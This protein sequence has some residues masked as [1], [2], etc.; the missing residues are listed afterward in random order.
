L[1]EEAFLLRNKEL[2]SL[3]IFGWGPAGE[4]K[5]RPLR[6]ET[7][8]RKSEAF[9]MADPKANP[10]YFSRYG[11]N[12]YEAAVNAI[13][14]NVVLALRSKRLPGLET[15]L[16]F[17]LEKALINIGGSFLSAY[18]TPMI[19]GVNELDIEY[20]SQ[21]IAAAISSYWKPRESA[22]YLAME[23][24]AISLTSHLITTKSANYAIPYINQNIGNTGVD[25][26]NPNSGLYQ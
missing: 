11:L 5:P 24:L 3:K 7:K 26:V 6:K 17:G 8:K 25:S 16:R 15:M 22:S 10:M 14:A 23:Q 20:L 18:L 19:S 13:A 1:E 2:R 4:G 12:F 9:S 21:A